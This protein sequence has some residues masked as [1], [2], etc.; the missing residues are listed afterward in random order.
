MTSQ[1][2]ISTSN[3]AKTSQKAFTA[4]TC[5]AYV[6]WH[7]HEIQISQNMWPSATKIHSTA[8]HL[9]E[10][11]FAFSFQK[12]LY[13][14]FFC[15]FLFSFILNRATFKVKKSCIVKGAKNSHFNYFSLSKVHKNRLPIIMKY[16][17]NRNLQPSKKIS[18]RTTADMTGVV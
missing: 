4:V 10:N 6:I 12:S 18:F 5:Q 14:Q 16:F 7:L 11:R 8:K 13:Q 17:H 3:K 15:L 1:Y 9:Q 2:A